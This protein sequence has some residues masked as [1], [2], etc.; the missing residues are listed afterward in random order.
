MDKVQSGAEPVLLQN[1]RNILCDL[2][3]DSVIPVVT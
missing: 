2:F 1:P 3:E